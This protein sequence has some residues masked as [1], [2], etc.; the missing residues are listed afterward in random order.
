VATPAER[1]AAIRDAF[2]AVTLPY[3]V[4]RGNYDLVFSVLPRLVRNKAGD[5]VGFE[6]YVRLFNNTTGVEQHIDPHRVIINPPLVPRANVTV[7]GQGNRVIGA[8]APLLAALEAVMDSIQ[9]TP[10]S[11][12]WLP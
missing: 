4:T 6:V 10:N 8:Q 1:W 2:S 11:Q 5:I 9:Q 12:G 3:T 7:D